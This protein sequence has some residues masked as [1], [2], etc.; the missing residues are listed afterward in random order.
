MQAMSLYL[1]ATASNIFLHIF[2]QVLKFPL[3][4][5]CNYIQDDKVQLISSFILLLLLL[6]LH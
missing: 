2:L 6:I 4:C 3:I 5:F 1:F